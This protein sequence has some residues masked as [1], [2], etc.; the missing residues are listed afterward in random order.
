MKTPIDSLPSV[1]P[2]HPGVTAALGSA[3]L[4]GAGTPLA[5]LLLDSVSP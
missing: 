1:R 5:K 3:V 2:W 4:F